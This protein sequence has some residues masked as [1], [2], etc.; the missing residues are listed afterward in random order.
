MLEF[1]IVEK[2]KSHFLY[3]PKYLFYIFILF[4][5]VL[6]LFGII[7]YFLTK[8]LFYIITIF[9]ILSYVA[10]EQYFQHK[11][12]KQIGNIVFSNQIILNLFEESYKFEYSELEI[13]FIDFEDYLHWETSFFS[14]YRDSGESNIISIK[15]NGNYYTFNFLS[16]SHKDEKKLRLFC[17]QL[18]RNGVPIEYIE[19]GKTIIERVTK[20]KVSN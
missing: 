3:N 20:N 5:I 14:F 19:K 11:L 6:K 17:Y 7:H 10:R 9:L 18:K 15:A 2:I 12:Y 16:A 1:K 8:E 4:A 13:L